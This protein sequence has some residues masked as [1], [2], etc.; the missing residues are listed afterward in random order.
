[1][2]SNSIGSRRGSIGAGVTLNIALSVEE[3]FAAF[4][5]SCTELQMWDDLGTDKNW[6]L[7]VCKHGHAGGKW[8][9]ALTKCQSMLD[10]AEKGEKL[11]SGACYV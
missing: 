2:G 4:E 6:W 1:M 7:Y 3:H 11:P 5:Q 8:G 10:K 9:L